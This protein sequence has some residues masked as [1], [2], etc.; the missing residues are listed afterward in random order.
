M[1]VFSSSLITATEAHA[2]LRFDEV[3]LYS[4][5]VGT[6]RDSLSDATS[7]LSSAELSRVHAIRPGLACDEFILGRACLRAL[8]ASEVSCD[9]RR[10]A[11]ATS[12]NGKPKLEYPL[13]HI[14]FNVSH[15]RGHILIALSASAA[16]GVDIEWAN[17]AV[18]SL[19]IARENFAPSELRAIA[20]APNGDPRA[21]VFS[22]IWAR[23][24][25]ILK[26]HGGGLLVPLQSFAVSLDP[27]NEQR[28]SWRD[29]GGILHDAFVRELQTTPGF[30]AALAASRPNLTLTACPLD[31]SAVQN[32]LQPANTR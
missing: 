4:F 2:P 16:L 9:P 32:L 26:L 1:G 12:A 6:A 28:V 15:S 25:A 31:L 14:A 10:L 22:R 7:L 8:L 21:R 24:E 20:D 27:I 19:D 17:P 11:I 23:K 5:D 30:A 3:R 13:S 29:P 18:E